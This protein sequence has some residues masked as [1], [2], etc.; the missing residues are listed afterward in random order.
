MSQLVLNIK[1]ENKA[2]ALLK[3]LESMDFVEIEQSSESKERAKTHSN[4]FDSAGIWKNRSIDSEDLRH[5]AWV[6]DSL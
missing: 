5:R 2:K 4:F 3:I 1:D 6:N